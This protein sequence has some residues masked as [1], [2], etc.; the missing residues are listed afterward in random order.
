MGLKH[1]RVFQQ[2]NYFFM[3]ICFGVSPAPLE[4][5]NFQTLYRGVPWAHQYGLQGIL[6]Q[7]HLEKN[8]QEIL[9]QR[10]ALYAKLKK[11]DVKNPWRIKGMSFLRQLAKD[12]G[13]WGSGEDNLDVS[14]KKFLEYY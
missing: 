6:A 11:L 1:N 10:R 14:G 3:I 7:D 4:N 2:K 5:I 9:E 8:A 13:W 12:R